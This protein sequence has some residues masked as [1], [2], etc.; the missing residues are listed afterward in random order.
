MPTS[1]FLLL[2]LLLA[3]GCE[4]DGGGATESAERD[5][6]I[7]LLPGYEDQITVEGI[8]SNEGHD[9]FE[10]ETRGNELVIRASN[11][12]AAA[13]GLNH[14]LKVFGDG[15][16]SWGGDRTDLGPSLPRVDGVVRETCPH[17]NRYIYNFTV[18]GYTTPHWEWP[19]WER[20][21]DLIA[22]HGFNMALVTVGNEKVTIQAL[23]QFG[24]TS[25]EIR[26][27]VV[28]PAY[29]AWQWMGNLQGDGPALSEDLIERR[30]LLGRRIAD[31]MRELGITPVVP[32][33]YGVVPPE[34]AERNGPGLDVKETGTWTGGFR[35]PDLLN[36]ADR[37]P[38]LEVADAFYVAIEDVFGEVTHFAADLFHEGT[39]TPGVDVSMAAGNVQEA[40]LRAHPEAI[41]VIQ[42]WFS[43]PQAELLAGLDP[44]S[45][46]VIDLWGDENPL[47]PSYTNRGVPPFD[48][49]PWVWS[50]LQNFGGRTG[51]HGNVDTL[52]T[53]YDENDGVFHHPSRGA[54]TGLAALMEATHQNP[55]VLDLLSEMI[56]RAPTEG[57]PV[58]DEWVRGYADRRY[59]PGSEEARNA[60]GSLRET[61]YSTSPGFQFGT[62]ESIICA[63][64]DLNAKNVFSSGP[65]ADPYYD[66]AQLES[67]LGDLLAARETLGGEDTY[68]YDLVD[69]TRQMLANRARGL[70]DDIRAAYEAEERE[71]FAELSDRFL[72]LIVDQDRL[73]A[74]RRELLL[75]AWIQN[76][77]AWGS[78]SEEADRLEGEARRLLTTWSEDESGLRE[79]AH[80]EWAGLVGDYYHGRWKL[81]FEHLTDQL[82]GGS[83][84]PPDFF[85]YESAWTRQTDP[86]AEDYPAAASGDSV[87]I[88]VELFE[89]YVTP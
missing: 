11:G 31:R 12:V 87:A 72:Q 75:G 58:L 17:T 66:M 6:V 36:P 5:L 7:R 64:P 20:E 41:W 76:A 2:A 13:S 44:Q 43:N 38:F 29:Q 69:V 61:A 40:M 46:L 80:R 74:T 65:P 34:F 53:L 30:A 86:L 59:G 48:G 84:S 15:H 16:L 68:A 23:E 56:W 22:A 18:S 47:Y 73:V 88:A 62:N 54:L 71:A 60:W 89:R 49:V 55:V 85:A 21:I 77:R 81:Y 83:S 1:R 39:V 3:A 79:Y 27:W 24:Y 32:G 52:A 70:L 4:S 37:E 78:T 82:A 67:A 8:P 25:E 10:L 28:G 45:A 35:R 19:Q 63:R 14:Y 26:E 9:V 51:L 42:G 57:P 33:F 50:I